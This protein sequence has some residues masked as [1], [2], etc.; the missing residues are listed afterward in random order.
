MLVTIRVNSLGN[1]ATDIAI[2]PWKVQYIRPVFMEEN[3]CYLSIGETTWRVDSSFESLVNIINT[4]RA[5]S[6]Q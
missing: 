2:D 1:T 6:K 3:T 4:A 5:G